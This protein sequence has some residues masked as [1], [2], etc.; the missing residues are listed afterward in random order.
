MFIIFS[1]IF[2]NHLTTILFYVIHDKNNYLNLEKMDVIFYLVL[3]LLKHVHK[4]FYVN[5]PFLL[6]CVLENIQI[7]FFNK[8]ETERDYQIKFIEVK[9]QTFDKDTNIYKILLY[10]IIYLKFQK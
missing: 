2:V 4:K 3:A 1:I 5:Y 10:D 7:S 9:D 6:K 8:L